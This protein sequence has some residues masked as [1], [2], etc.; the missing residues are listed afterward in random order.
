[1]FGMHLVHRNRSEEEGAPVSPGEVEKASDM[2]ALE[3]V[4]ESHTG[5]PVVSE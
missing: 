2:E 4:H 5:L 3:S 1:M